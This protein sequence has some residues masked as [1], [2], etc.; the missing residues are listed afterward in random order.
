M[1]NIL[2][3]LS[4]FEF[5]FYLFILAIFFTIFSILLKNKYIK[6]LNLIFFGIFLS[7]S[8]SELL[9][10]ITSCPILVKNR[11]EHI[12]KLDD[13]QLKTLRY[14][15][16][17]GVNDKIVFE[18]T[19]TNI[20]NIIKDKSKIVFDTKV[21]IYNN[22]FRYTK[23]NSNSDI[24]IV[25]LGCSNTYGSGLNDNQ[26]LPFYFS[27]KYNFDINVLN[28]SICGAGINIAYNII[29]SGVLNKLL[30]NKK[31][32]IKY[33]IYSAINEHIE[34]SFRI[35]CFDFSDDNFILENGKFVRA[36][37]P[38]GFLKVIFKKSYIFHKFFI[39][40]INKKNKVFHEQYFVE[41]TIKMKNLAKEKYNAEL[42]VIL[43]PD[44][45]EK[46]IEKLKKENINLI[47]LDKKFYKEEYRIKND[48][49]PNEKANKEIAQILFDYINNDK[50]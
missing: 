34:R 45:E 23:G 42:I 1:Y 6:K 41:R 19:N 48:G 29:N 17:L 39:D 37:E 49:H 13:L 18:D 11:A 26:T 22:S 10:C 43:W 32:Q 20:D 38:L 31:S 28:C 21:Q 36:K 24:S 2:F 30:I 12:Y 3:Y 8:I 46:I 27:E 33:F 35:A 16:I 14:L 9:F 7:L 5:V 15:S 25:F 50:S 47:I 44:I 4:K 40:F